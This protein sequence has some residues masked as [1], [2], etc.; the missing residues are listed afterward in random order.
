MPIW[1]LRDEWQLDEVNVPR[2]ALLI[3]RELAYPDLDITIYLQQVSELADRAADQVPSDVPVVDR[4]ER[5]ADYLF[6]SLGF[7]GDSSDYYDPRNSYLNDVLERRVGLPILLSV[8][9][10][11]LANRL[12]LPAYGIS[13]PGHFIVGVGSGDDTYRLDPF[14]GGR[15][16]SLNDCAELIQV[17]VGYEGPLDAAWFLPA[18]ERDILT[19]IVN[20]LRGTYVRR[21]VWPQ[22][23]AAIH[24]LRLMQPQTPEHLRD[25]G[26]VYYREGSLSQAAY[27]LNEYLAYAPHAADAPMIREGMK[28]TLDD[29]VLLN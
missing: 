28:D 18:D 29:W 2:A 6:S 25:L 11:D 20:N 7:A 9:Y 19:R 12:G 1:T 10:V 8:V 26:L 4:A 5:L 17:A 22:A 23:A 14:H 21:Q 3:A 16:L 27:F 15:W 13:L 24:L